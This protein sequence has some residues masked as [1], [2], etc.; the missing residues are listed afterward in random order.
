MDTLIS[1]TQKTQKFVSE[2]GGLVQC[3]GVVGKSLS[4]SI[5]LLHTAIANACSLESEGSELSDRL[6]Q[7]K[8]AVEF[9]RQTWN[10]FTKRIK[11]YCHFA[12]LSE[13][14]ID[15]MKVRFKRCDFK[16]IKDYVEQL[17]KYLEQ[18]KECYDEFEKKYSQAGKKCQDA[19]TYCR[20]K[21]DGAEFNKFLAQFLS[22]VMNSMNFG[23]AVGVGSL[24]MGLSL[25][26]ALATGAAVN[27]YVA[28]PVKASS[29]KAAGFYGNQATA[30]E[31]RHEELIKLDNKLSELKTS[32]EEMLEM[33][34]DLKMDVD[35][36]CHS[37]KNESK[38]FCKVFDILQD[39]IKEKHLDLCGDSCSIYVEK[40]KKSTNNKLYL[41]IAILVVVVA[42][43]Y[44]LKN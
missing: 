30:F 4:E 33:L 10:T 43:I 14:E 19:S 24:V 5:E 22:D 34:R 3:I 37:I 40:T 8:E 15:D 17:W 20:K 25:T 35:N 26:M 41:F 11:T 38:Q 9:S 12:H 21:K 6:R 44:M 1:N 16:P 2:L 13:G 7:C 36:I 18:S 29:Q 31:E 23:V 32:I 27:H 42:I 39:G 28:E